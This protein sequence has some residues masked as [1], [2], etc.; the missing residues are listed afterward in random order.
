MPLEPPPGS[1]VGSVGLVGSFG[2]ED[3]LKRLKGIHWWLY[4]MNGLLRQE[5]AWAPKMR[6]RNAQP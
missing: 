3:E 5:A 1:L 6:K 4:T 2:L